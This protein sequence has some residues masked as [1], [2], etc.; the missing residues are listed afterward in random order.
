MTPEDHTEIKTV[1]NVVEFF[2]SQLCSLDEDFLLTMW[3]VM[4]NWFHGSEIIEHRCAGTAPLSSM[5][6]VKTQTIKAIK[7]I[8]K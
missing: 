1:L 8:P 5:R 2:Y 6:L 4:D 7:N 3:V